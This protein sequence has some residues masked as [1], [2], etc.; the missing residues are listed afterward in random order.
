[1]E[2]ISL[3]N[4]E[5]NEVTYDKLYVFVDDEGD[6]IVLP[7]LWTVHLAC[8]SSVHGWH[9]KGIFDQMAPGDSKRKAINI[10]KTLEEDSVATNTVDNYIGHFFHF[11]E[12]I[13]KLH[14]IQK[15]PSVHHTELV[16]NEFINEYLNKV[17]PERLESSASLKAHQAAISAYYSFLLSLKIKDS[18]Q[19]T[20]FPET[21]KV[22]AEKDSRPQKI[23]YV[24]RSE[25]K[26]LLNACSCD[27][28][29][30]ILRMGYEVGLR[31]EE[32][33][34]L[35]LVK[36]KARN[37]QQL[38]LLDLFDELDRLPT[39][40]SFTFVLNGKFTKGGKTRDINFDRD[41]LEAMK[42]YYENKR[43]D[44]MKI[45]N[46][47]CDTLF[48]R[49][50]NE[51]KGK[52]ISAEQASNLFLGLKKL[53]PN[54]NQSLSYHDLRHTFATGLYHSKMYDS[55]GSHT[56]SQ[57]EA[58]LEVSLLLG[59]SRPETTVRYI[60]NELQMRKIEGMD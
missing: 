25:I 7:L 2:R 27:R 11:L 54:M 36:H 22:M 23:N 10:T 21:K 13:N 33:R 57:N 60:R 39:A 17:L 34:G 15:T 46:R 56:R 45:S 9:I 47:S 3:K 31:T 40:D 41:L 53:F 38:G 28:D 29:K 52:P 43:S 37:K 8:K 4:V 51:G 59:H 20:I 18:L 5:F 6:V 19:S 48:V 35:V 44:V 49:N 32:N 30:L 1:M 50:D 42:R 16:S 24:S 26:S 58:L 55:Y 12:Y 14:K